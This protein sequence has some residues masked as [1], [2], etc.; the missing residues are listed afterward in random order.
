MLGGGGEGGEKC[1]AN[2]L[3][4]IQY[5]KLGGREGRGGGTEGGTDD[6]NKSNRLLNM[7]TLF[8]KAGTKCNLRHTQ[9]NNYNNYYENYTNIGE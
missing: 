1:I 7:I 8:Q 2:T 3:K 9:F 5:K 4:E 6:R